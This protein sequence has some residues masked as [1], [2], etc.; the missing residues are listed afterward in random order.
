MCIC[1]TMT[2]E[3]DIDEGNFM[4]NRA[5]HE[6]NSSNFELLK[7]WHILSYLKQAKFETTII[8]EL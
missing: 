2:N 7:V 8:V 3:A 4:M 6:H 5:D 1:T